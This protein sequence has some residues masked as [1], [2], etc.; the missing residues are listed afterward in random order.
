M[1]TQ[2]ILALARQGNPKAISDLLNG[3]IEAKGIKAQVAKQDHYLHI[4]LESARPLNE[5]TTVA[6][7][8]KAVSSLSIDPNSTVKVY[9]RLSGQKPIAWSH[10]IS[11]SALPSYSTGLSSNQHFDCQRDETLPT[12]PHTTV[13][14]MDNQVHNQFDTHPPA[15]T[16]VEPVDIAMPDITTPIASLETEVDLPE[17]E[18][19]IDSQMTEALLDPWLYDPEDLW[20]THQLDSSSSNN[21]SNETV[22]SLL[23]R[24]EAVILLVFVSLFFLWDFYLDFIEDPDADE[25]LTSGELARRLGVNRSTISRRKE[26]EDFAQWAKDLDPDGV[27]WVYQDGMFVPIA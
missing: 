25:P 13:T 27:A 24:P 26:R 21:N 7:I 12:E 16:R 22:P 19:A 5:E 14:Q 1:A 18:V 23:Q 10:E 6:F 11:S 2:D 3:L 9:S 4:L 17:P 8:H 15:D 20:A